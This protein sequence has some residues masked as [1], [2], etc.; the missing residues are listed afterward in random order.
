MENET[1]R[2]HLG[3]EKAG[4]REESPG[5]NLEECQMGQERNTEKQTKKEEIG[6]QQ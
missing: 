6:G 1:G 2:V 3:R 4:R 5:Q